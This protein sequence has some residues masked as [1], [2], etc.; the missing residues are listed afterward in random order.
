ML[1]AN[2]QI[3]FQRT[4]GASASE[5]APPGSAT[6]SEV[7]LVLLLELLSLSESDDGRNRLIVN[8]TL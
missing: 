8:C 2:S 1:D 6:D 5:S 3:R 4:C 7:V